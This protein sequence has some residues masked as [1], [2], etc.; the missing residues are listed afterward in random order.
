[1]TDHANSQALIVAR[2]SRGKSQAEVASA[3]GITQGAISKAENDT[4]ALTHVQIQ[5]IA[6]YLDYPPSFFY[7]PGRLRDGASMCH[8]HWKRKTLP[9]KV[10]NRVNA[11]MFARNVNVRHLMNGLEIVGPRRFHALDVDEFGSAEHVARALRTAW[12]V[13]DGPIRNLVELVESAGAIVILAPFGHRKLFGMSCWPTSD[14]PLFYMNS[15]ISMDQS[16]WTIAHELGHLTMHGTPT[17]EDI[18]IE[19]DCFAAEFLMPQASIATDLH[20]LTIDR[21][22]PLKLHWGVSMK[23]LIKRAEQLRSVTRED[24]LRLYKAYSARGFNAREPYALATEAP[25]LMARAIKVHLEQHGYTT[26]ELR[27]AMRL[28]SDDDFQE[29]AGSPTKVR[30]LSVVRL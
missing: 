6:A 5:R 26:K 17:A 1:M 14:Y 29:I 24:A 25:T 15:E 10:L 30:R 20:A 4:L 21:L 7:E 3:T 27:D 28:L 12:R 13:P 19:A 8:Y 11:A 22:G 9:A 16:R 2:E 18:E 23:A